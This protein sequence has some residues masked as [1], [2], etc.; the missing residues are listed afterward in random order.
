MKAKNS[1]G[2]MYII[3]YQRIMHEKN[4]ETSTVAQDRHG[5]G[6]PAGLQELSTSSGPSTDL[7]SVASVASSGSDQKIMRIAKQ[8]ESLKVAMAGGLPRSN[9]E[10]THEA[11]PGSTRSSNDELQTPSP[12]SELKDAMEPVGEKISQ[13]VHLLKMKKSVMAKPGSN[14]PNT[15]P[16][17]QGSKGTSKLP[18]KDAENQYVLPSH[19]PW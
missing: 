13:I 10:S 14:Q 1:H 16:A 5:C 12:S 4:K 18:E 9:P 8:F 19:V 3:V 17:E 2:N 7:S 6:D 15:Q 11:E